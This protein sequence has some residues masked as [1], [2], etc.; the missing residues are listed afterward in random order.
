MITRLP[1]SPPRP[2]VPAGIRP[3]AAAGT[4]TLAARMADMVEWVSVNQPPRPESE[5]RR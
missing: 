3:A 1:A 2:P 5:D 4:E